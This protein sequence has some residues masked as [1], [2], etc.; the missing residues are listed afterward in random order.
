MKWFEF[1]KMKNI[2]AI[3]IKCITFVPQFALSLALG[4]EESPDTK[5]WHS[6]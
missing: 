6:G 1:Y 3:L 2:V 4:S 5:E